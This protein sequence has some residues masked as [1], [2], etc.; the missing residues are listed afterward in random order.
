[1]TRPPAVGRKGVIL[2]SARAGRPWLSPDSRI[3][4]DSFA[5]LVSQVTGGDPRVTGIYRV[6]TRPSSG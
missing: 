1:M 3:K 4:G 6:G 2:R 5:G